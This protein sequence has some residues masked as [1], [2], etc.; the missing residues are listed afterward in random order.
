M[1]LFQEDPFNKNNLCEII[2]DTLE[3]LLSPIVIDAEIR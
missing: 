3:D 1:T 2:L